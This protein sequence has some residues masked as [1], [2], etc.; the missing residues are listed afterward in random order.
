M[1]VASVADPLIVILT[2]SP[3]LTCGLSDAL[4]SGD[5]ETGAGV[6]VAAVFGVALLFAFELFS[7]LPGSQAASASD[8]SI[9][10]KSFF[11][12]IAL[13]SFQLLLK[14]SA[15]FPSSLGE[16]ESSA[17]HFMPGGIFFVAARARTSDG[18]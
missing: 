7:V 1:T 12:M 10:A 5:G 6:E 2:L 14:R 17:K 15:G 16:W 4:G 8:S 11:I 3:A 18:S 13:H 9:T